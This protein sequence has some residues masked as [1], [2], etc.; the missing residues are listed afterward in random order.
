MRVECEKDNNTTTTL[1]VKELRKRVKDLEDDNAGDDGTRVKLTSRYYLAHDAVQNDRVHV[2]EINRD[3]VK[4][5]LYI[6][7]QV[8]IF[9]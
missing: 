2:Q 5:V 6:V 8:Q 4:K 7:E 1:T 3:G 9:Y